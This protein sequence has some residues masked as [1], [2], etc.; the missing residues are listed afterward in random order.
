[1]LT[2]T[3][4]QGVARARPKQGWTARVVAAALLGL[5]WLAIGGGQALAVTVTEFPARGTPIGITA[6]PDGNLWFTENLGPGVAKAAPDGTV[7][8]Y[9]AGITGMFPGAIVNGPDG[10]LWFTEYPNKIGAIT[11]AGVVTEYSQGITADGVPRAITVGAD[12]NLWFTED[13][14]KLARITTGG[15]VTEFSTGITHPPSAIVKGSDGNLW[16]IE[17][18]TDQSRIGRANTNGVV[19]EF[20]AG[21]TPRTQLADI[22]AGPD[23]A[24]WFTEVDARAIGRITTGGLISERPATVTGRP[25]EIV[26]GPDGNLWFTVNTGF[27]GWLARMTPGG[28]VREFKAGITPGS[29]LRDLTAGPDGTLWFTDD[30]ARRIGRVTLDPPAAITGAAADVTPTGARLTGSVNPRD[31]AT[32]YTFEYGPTTAYGQTTP[33]QGAGDGGSAGPVG[34]ELSGLTPQVTYHYRVSATSSRGTT[35]GQDATFTTPAHPPAQP[36]TPPA[37]PALAPPVA[38][39]ASLDGDG[40]GVL[41]PADCDDTNPRRFAGAHDV[42][43]NGVDEDCDG[44]DARVPHVTSTVAANWLAGGVTRVTRLR[45]T[46]IPAGGAVNIVCRGRG[47]PFAR[48]RFAPGRTRAVKATRDFRRARLRSGAV[49]EVRIVAPGA[50]GKVVRYTIRRHAIPRGRVLC[51][52]PGASRPAACSPE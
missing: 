44:R 39:A 42:P 33:V 9:K 27:D 34:A 29:H 38:P 40:D 1:L 28:A 23:G 8:L 18:S 51:L 50:V 47:C 52:P 45:V 16:F 46:A 22:A 21:L 3:G 35:V 17:S 5:G 6:G 11:T 31:Y 49:L 20:F 48:R 7:T 32:T 12:N 19:D 24:L 2:A 25:G 4:R 43:S 26:T 37:V 13:A 30:N 10:R 41:T 36:D 15:T 14:K